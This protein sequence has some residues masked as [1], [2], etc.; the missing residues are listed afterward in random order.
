MAMLFDTPASP[1]TVPDLASP[2]IPGSPQPIAPV[3][4]E[5]LRVVRH[6]PTS[7]QALETLGPIAST[8]IPESPDEKPDG[9]VITFRHGFWASRRSATWKALNAADAPK[10]RVDRFERCGCRA[11][12][13][14]ATDGSGR[15]RLALDKCHDRLCEACAV[16][17]RRTVCR[18]LR[19]Q[20]P[21]GDVRLITLTLKSCTHPLADQIDRIYG[22]FKNLRG[23]KFWTCAVTGGVCF[24]ELTLN[25][26]TGLFHP[27]LHVLVSGKYIPIEQ[28]REAWLQHTG[29][30]YVVHVQFING[31]E[32]AASYV[33]KYA[34]K[35]INASVWRNHSALTEC[36]TALAG[37]RSFNCFGTWGKMSLSRVPEDDVGWAAVA[38]LALIMRKARSGDVTARSIMAW[39]R[40]PR[41]AEPVTLEVPDG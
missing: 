37:R 11:W 34:G 40:G 36:V 26:D 25:N 22:A 8:S 9:E 2:L 3:I 18:N 27:H 20:I 24:L 5:P 21:P 6:L 29:D 15:Y 19:E 10:G 30:S 32:H 14:R 39:F 1:R 12:V 38:P 17:R 31:A 23:E 4:V 16:E 41:A 7:V 13:L 35:A 28:I 33:A